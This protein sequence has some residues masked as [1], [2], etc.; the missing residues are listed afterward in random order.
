MDHLGYQNILLLLKV[1]YGIEVKQLIPQDIC[2]DYMK[3]RQ[4][5]IPSY[6]PMSQPTEYFDYLHCDLGSFYLTTR[7]SNR[8]YLGIRDGAR[9]AYYA[10]PMRTKSQ[11]FDTFQ[12]FIRQAERQSNK[13]LSIYV[14]ILVGN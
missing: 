1:A 13:S 6:K 7:R 2:G 8:F 4:Q 11:T 10:E 3:R 12:K 9:G 5:K 14:L